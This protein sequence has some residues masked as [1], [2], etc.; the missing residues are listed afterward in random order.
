MLQELFQQGCKAVQARYLYPTSFYV[1]ALNQIL[2][3]TFDFSDNTR[4]K[5]NFRL[6]H[7]F[8]S[9]RVA[10]SSCRLNSKCA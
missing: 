1:Y 9:A 7:F 2:N 10:L 8:R 3:N 4:V 6:A 5:I